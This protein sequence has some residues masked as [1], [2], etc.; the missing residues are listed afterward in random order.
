MYYV[1]MWL[2]IKFYVIIFYILFQGGGRV[3][4]GT[5]FCHTLKGNHLSLLLCLVGT[6]GTVMGCHWGTQPNLHN[7]KCVG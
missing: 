4:I 5:T 1:T 6:M 2:L 3:C 7:R